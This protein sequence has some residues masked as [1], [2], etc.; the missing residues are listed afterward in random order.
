MQKRGDLECQGA[1]EGKSQD[2]G[3]VP[4]KESIQS[5]LYQVRELSE[6]LF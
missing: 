2:G 3:C 4:G 6:R 5:R 1:G